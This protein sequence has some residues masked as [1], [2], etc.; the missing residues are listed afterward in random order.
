VFNV[1]IFIVLQKKKKNSSATTNQQNKKKGL[2][3]AEHLTGTPL[4]MT[5]DVSFHILLLV[6]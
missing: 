3:L 6:I 1:P 2:F 4:R 5:N